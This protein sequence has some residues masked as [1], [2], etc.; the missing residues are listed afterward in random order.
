M[1]NDLS[2]LM[3]YLRAAEYSHEIDPSVKSPKPII[4]IS[5]QRGANGTLIAQMVAEHL[6]QKNREAQPWVVI[7]RNLT[8]HVMEDHH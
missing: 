2:H 7:D 3:A 4:T 1:K 8:Q 6:T 5:R